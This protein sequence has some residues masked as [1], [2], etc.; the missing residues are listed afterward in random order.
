MHAGV[1]ASARG[2]RTRVGA[3]GTTTDTPPRRRFQ[4]GQRA[5]GRRGANGR[6][7]TLCGGSLAEQAFCCM[8]S[9]IAPSV[10]ADC[11]D[12]LPRTRRSPMSLP[13]SAESGIPE[14]TVRVARAAF[15]HGNPYMRMRD[16]FGSI[17]TNPPFAA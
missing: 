2:R 10:M 5:Q 13:A 11:A 8:L 7:V 17:F 16:A 1:L 4:R 14:D 9:P 3:L 6:D 12:A 15:P